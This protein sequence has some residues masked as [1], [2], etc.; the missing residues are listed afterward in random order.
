MCS[1]DTFEDDPTSKGF[2]L[3]FH[4][5]KT[6][7]ADFMVCSRALGRAY[8]M[9]LLSCQRMVDILMPSYLKL[10]H[11]H[12]AASGNPANPAWFKMLCLFGNHWTQLLVFTLS[13]PTYLD[14]KGVEQPVMGQKKRNELLD[15]LLD[16]KL[17]EVRLIAMVLYRGFPLNS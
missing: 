17:P 4:E 14:S 3:A 8:D 15:A 10:A 5:I 9:E 2:S 6:R 13:D 12:L 1:I 11:A 7:M 16:A